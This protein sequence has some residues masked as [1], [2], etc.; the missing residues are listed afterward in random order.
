[1][2]G[3]KNS[4]QSRDI[5]R[6]FYL[7]EKEDKDNPLPNIPAKVIIIE[8][9]GSYIWEVYGVSDDSYGLETNFLLNGTELTFFSKSI[10]ILK[11]QVHQYRF[12]WDLLASGKEGTTIYVDADGNGE[13]EETRKFGLNVNC[14]EF[15]KKFNS[16]L[17]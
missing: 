5:P 15:Y 4:S 2:T 8:P 9:N 12:D 3:E 1:M 6:S 7:S 11:S 16:G 10:T 14:Q 13:L 17:N